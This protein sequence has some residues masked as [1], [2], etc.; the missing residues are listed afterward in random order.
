MAPGF[1][2][3][4]GLIPEERES[5][6]PSASPPPHCSQPAPKAL[7]PEWRSRLFSVLWTLNKVFLSLRHWFPLQ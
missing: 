5:S 1:L 7:G 6:S 2:E 3:G 4:L